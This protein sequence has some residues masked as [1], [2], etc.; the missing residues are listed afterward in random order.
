METTP[1]GKS[2][3]REIAERAAEVALGYVPIAGPVL[4][5]AFVTAVGWRLDQRR[6][7][8]LTRL[9]EGLEDL[10]ERIGDV[11]FENL[12]SNDLFVDAVVTT[13]RTIYHTHQKDDRGSWAPRDAGEAGV[14]PTRRQRPHVSRTDDGQPAGH[15]HV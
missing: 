13:T 12:A 2:T 3:S 9:A 5:A 11:D 15:G 6:D 1:P 8:W 7:E 14:L 10:R 4:A